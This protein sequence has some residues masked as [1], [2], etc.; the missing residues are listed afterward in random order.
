MEMNPMLEEELDF[1]QCAIVPPQ[2]ISYDAKTSKV[3]STYWDYTLVARLPADY[4]ADHKNISIRVTPENKKIHAKCRKVVLEAPADDCTLVDICQRFRSA[5]DEWHKSTGDEDEVQSPVNF[6][7][8]TAPLRKLLESTGSSPTSS[9][10]HAPARFDFTETLQAIQQMDDC[11]G[12]SKIENCMHTIS[13]ETEAVGSR[14]THE[15]TESKFVRR[16]RVNKNAP[17][18]TL[19]ATKTV[20]NIKPMLGP[21]PLVEDLEFVPHTKYTEP[22][23]QSFS[24]MTWNV[25]SELFDEED[26]KMSAQRFPLIVRE[27]QKSGADIIALQEITPETWEKLASEPAIKSLY[28]ITKLPSEVALGQIFLTKAKVLKCE[29]LRL[30]VQKHAI[31]LTLS[32]RTGRPL[33]A[34]NIQLISDYAKNAAHRRMSELATIGQYINDTDDTILLGDFNFGDDDEE[35]K[36]VPWGSF[37]DAWHMLR[38]TEHG[39]TFD[40]EN[41]DLAKIT[42]GPIETSRRLDKIKIKGLLVP[43]DIHTTAKSKGSDD[44]RPS[45]H[46]AVR[47]MLMQEK[48]FSPFEHGVSLDMQTAIVILPPEKLWPQINALRSGRDPKFP[49]WMPHIPLLHPFINIS[50]SQLPTVVHALQC[51]AKRVPPFR[52]HLNG[53]STVTEKE[54]ASIYLNAEPLRPFEGVIRRLFAMLTAA[55]SMC[56][57]PQITKVPIGTCKAKDAASIVIEMESEWPATVFDVQQIHVIT[58]NSQRD[59]MR[60]CSSIQ[61]GFFN[62]VNSKGEPANITHDV[63]PNAQSEPLDPPALVL[64]NCPTLHANPKQYVISDSLEKWLYDNSVVDYA[65]RWPTHYSQRGAMYHIPDER[66]GA[67]LRA[68][69]EAVEAKETF[70]IEERRS[71]RFRLYVD[72]DFK[73]ASKDKNGS[74]RVHLNDTKL[75]ETILTHAM[76]FFDLKDPTVCVTSAH[77]RMYDKANPDVQ[78]KSGYHVFFQNVWVNSKVYMRFLQSL[79]VVCGELLS[80]PRQCVDGMRWK[81]ILNTFNAHNDR[82]RLVGSAKRRKGT[83]RKYALHGF[84]SVDRSVKGGFS[85]TPRVNDL[86]TL[87]ARHDLRKAVMNAPEKGLFATMTS[88]WGSDCVEQRWVVLD[89]NGYREEAFYPE[90]RIS[91]EYTKAVDE[92]KRAKE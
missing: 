42:C 5:V 72:I 19:D 15:D 58:R 54:T 82:C 88:S 21:Y 43:S 50:A 53:F 49:R 87:L 46:F 55:Y 1:L 14:T 68:W 28:T 65:G 51:I 4:P 73:C 45:S 52:V 47:A 71:E 30:S 48:S 78:S 86:Y 3:K 35:E 75:L 31:M 16:S 70:Y 37:I 77:T 84:F 60:V 62:S 22:L 23:P 76:A 67:F 85:G 11:D 59:A 40:V 8:V 24:V 44:L 12:I 20:K 89:K 18:S 25:L 64:E 32:S 63:P 7:T 79:A 27:I 38:G 57:A 90:G 13:F 80:V 56:C 81:N 66:I 39:A 69:R 91:E 10:V 74:T 26:K 17:V 29:V 92:L 9:P 2:T 36:T 33:R 6:F 34:V 83:G 61:L 41:N